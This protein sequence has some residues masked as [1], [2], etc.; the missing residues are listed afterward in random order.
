MPRVSWA[1]WPFISGVLFAQTPASPPAAPSAFTVASIKPNKSSDDRFML[2]P[3]PGGGLTA[4]GVTLKMLIMNAYVVRSYQLSGGL[5]WIGTERWDIE[6][7]T[8]GAPARL[9]RQQ[10][11]ILLQGLLEDRFQLKTHREAKEMQVYALVATKGGS[12]LKPHPD[13]PVGHRPKLSILSGSATFTD[14]SVERLVSQLALQLDRPILDRTGLTG[15]YDF[16][17]EW[18]PAPG[19]SGPEVFGLPPRAE[20]PR[21]DDSNGPSLFTALEEQLGLRLESTKSP[22]D[23]LVV[24]HVERPSEN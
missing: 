2:R 13:E 5:A 16:K 11:A 18:S 15:N 3:M 17:L 6:A 1:F 7:K 9:S 24:D 21:A 10:F 22:V 23:V 8:E 4:T 14:A 20:P 12:K 19:E